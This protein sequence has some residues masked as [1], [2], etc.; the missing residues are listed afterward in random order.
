MANTASESNPRGQA[1]WLLPAKTRWPAQPDGYRRRVDLL[2][3]MEPLRRLTVL[4][5][6]G[7]FGKT[8]LL[9]DACRRWLDAG[10]LVAWLTLDADDAPGVI[11]AYLAYAFS[12]AGLHARDDPRQAESSE[13]EIPHR[14]RRRTEV[15]AATIEAH[16]APCLLALDDVEQLRHPEA[17]DTVDFLVRH[18][19]PN[20]RFAFAMRDN[21]GLDLDGVDA[22]RRCLFGAED[23]RFS[24]AQIEGFFDGALSP[25]ELHAVQRRTEG[26]PVALR[27]YSNER[28][29][30]QQGGPGANGPRGK[31]P[32]LR[33]PID[34]LAKQRG[35]TSSAA[36]PADWFGQ[37]LLARLRPEDRALL[38]D[39]ALFDWVSPPL[40]DKV[41]RTANVQRRLAEVVAL[42]G[43]LLPQDRDGAGTWRMNPLLKEYCAEQA[44]SENPERYRALQRRIAR[45]E[46][47]AGHTAP[48]LRHA[49]EAG[50]DALT[51]EIL[52]QAGGVRMWACF[53]V[54]SL[55]AVDEFLNAEVIER[56]PRAALLHCCVLVLQARFGEAFA[57]YGSLKERTSGFERDRAGGDDAALKMDH[58]LVVATLAGF[59]CLP[60]D[61]PMVQ[62]ALRDMEGAVPDA[63]NGKRDDAANG[64]DAVVEGALNLSLCLAEQQRTRFEAAGRRG[65]A[66]KR[67]FARRDADYGGVFVNLALGALAM[68]QGRV[69]QAEDWY[70]Q[71][72]PTAIADV[73]SLEL[74]FERSVKPAAATEH[75][76][77][78]MPEVGWMDVYAAAYGVAAEMAFDAQSA[79]S[80]VDLSLEYARSKGLVT[81]QRFLTALRISWL[82][83]DGFIDE[84]ERQWRADGL[85]TETAEV[86][87]P[88]RQTWREMEAIACA[89]IRLFI[90]RGDLLAARPLVEALCRSAEERRL[91]R[92]LMNGVALSMATEH[93]LGMLRNAA[94]DLADFLRIAAVSDYVRPLARERETTLEVL[95]A[96]LAAREEA[97]VHPAASRLLDELAEPV[98]EVPIFTAREMAIVRRVEQNQRVDEIAQALDM[99]ELHLEA[100]LEAI[101]HKTGAGEGEDVL[102]GNRL[103]PPPGP[104]AARRPWRGRRTRPRQ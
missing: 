54:K 38:L 49:S 5:A 12:L 50:D 69:R 65:M 76:L 66:S 58:L 44:R 28:N 71:G 15:L 99:S 2:Q 10:H 33:L 84:A 6:P 36:A 73:L 92:V 55:I 103:R 57:L 104:A 96:L 70:G 52:E 68:A 102:R 27:I 3:R 13:G 39:I 74:Q 101:R 100:H 93:G 67:A 35:Q 34:L 94:A 61:H 22:A 95:P 21:P 83:R 18:G 77:P 42:D 37:R 30:R 26:W 59:N 90:A 47:Q 81:V 89:R 45:L 85:P 7:G 60:F 11:D 98:A 56:F 48:A 29:A 51:G 20:L 31:N 43:L 91:Q 53:G 46:A 23:L 97:D 9:A 32:R 86:L 88:D 78:P 63:P 87:D 14:A 75:N 19:P 8:C 64:L 1:A 25:K 24:S 80:S 72:A 16:A 41:L 82:V 4:R 79:R 62:K 17:L 40:V